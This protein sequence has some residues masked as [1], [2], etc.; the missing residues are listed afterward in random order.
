MDFSH[1]DDDAPPVA[2]PDMINVVSSTATRRRARRRRATGLL[3]V[4]CS[5]AMMFG[6]L[7]VVADPSG[8]RR[9]TVLTNGPTTAS[10]PT[11]STLVSTTSST[12]VRDPDIWVTVDLIVD[13]RDVQSGDE[14]TGTVIFTNHTGRRVTFANE[15]GC[16]SKWH[17]LVTS[18]DSRPTAWIETS[19][20]ARA[21][22]SPTSVANSPRGY[23]DFPP[24]ITKVPF[25][26]TTYE[27]ICMGRC[28]KA[29][30]PGRAFVWFVGRSE[31]MRL[32]PFFQVVITP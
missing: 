5:V 26:A 3:A 10:A 4:A 31:H 14:L 17:V 23:S 9:V 7:N 28:P 15:N 6:I 22:A 13:A 20:C 27:P 16:L 21:L 8:Q 12:T 1:L 19:E 30:L 18:E 11:S 32:P 24:G 2:G 29:L 25:S